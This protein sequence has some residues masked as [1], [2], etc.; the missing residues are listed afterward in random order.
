MS[1]LRRCELPGCENEFTTVTHRRF[2]CME[3]RR[4]YWNRRRSFRTGCTP[5]KVGIPDAWDG[6][7][8][9]NP[10]DRARYAAMIRA[11]RS[12]EVIPERWRAPTVRVAL[13]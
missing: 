5:R 6:Y 12:V 11:Q 2:C 3:H 4:I 7:D 1:T 8:P 9:N 10:D 13:G